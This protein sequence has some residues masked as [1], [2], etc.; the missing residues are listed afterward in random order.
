MIEGLQVGREENSGRS[1][2]LFEGYSA[3]TTHKAIGTSNPFIIA[4]PKN[5][6]FSVFVLE[7]DDSEEMDNLH[8]I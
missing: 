6:D 3:Q 7:N 5:K 1:G 8:H 2:D 4:E